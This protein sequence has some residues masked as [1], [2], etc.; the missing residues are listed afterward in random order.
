MKNHN[1]FFVLLALS[2]SF[3]LQAQDTVTIKNINEPVIYTIGYNRVP[4]QYNV[5]LIG[6]INVAKG[7]YSGLQLG[8][9]N[10]TADSFKGIAIGF[11]N[12]VGDSNI[13]GLIGFMNTVGDS[14]KGLTVG[15][16]NTVGD[17]GTGAQIGF[18][19]TLGDSFHGLHVGFFNTIG[20]SANGIQAGFFN[21]LGDSFHGLQTGF[22]NTLGDNA[23][24]LQ[25]GFFNTM[26]NS[27]RGIQL[28]FVNTVGNSVEGV[29]LGFLNT[30]P[31]LRGLQLGFI[32]RIDTVEKGIPVG[33][34][35]F[36]KKG[37]YQALE[38]GASGMYPLNISYKT[39]IKQF[40]TSLVFSYS[41]V[42]H[43]HFAFGMGVG[44]IIPIN[45]TLS[46]NPEVLTQST[47]TVNWDQIHSLHLNAVYK[48]S[49]RFSLVAG[50]TLVW[51]H[52]NDGTIFHKPVFSLY[53]TELNSK[54][55]LL[56][57]LNVAARFSIGKFEK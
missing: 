34:L 23:A 1:I 8:F 36:V 18:F 44:T 47:Y 4:D 24:G 26:G 27:F 54:N 50:P 30:T 13:G 42:S 16:F 48:L 55:N 28:G 10:S 15:F 19:N 43:N 46:F 7:N 29:E 14:S 3:Q 5:P 45:N 6:F 9:T 32:N 33:F 40:Y 56:I 2:V 57:G 25:I 35:T 20:D 11:T 17:S 38:V 37:G 22:F 41:P 39:G 12:S 21:T 49:D 53:T 52:L 31:K 51:N